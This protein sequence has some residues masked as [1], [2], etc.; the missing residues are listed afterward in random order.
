MALFR[1]HSKN[2]EPQ[3]E[4]DGWNGRP[5]PPM[6]STPTTCIEPVEPELLSRC[7]NADS[8]ASKVISQNQRAI[9]EVVHAP[10]QP[11]MLAQLSDRSNGVLVITAF[12]V[13]IFSNGHLLATYGQNEIGE[14]DPH[15]LG[16]QVYVRF[17]SNG[18]DLPIVGGQ[19]AARDVA[20]L[21]DRTVLSSTR[22]DLTALHASM[23]PPSRIYPEIIFNSLRRQ[24]L[25]T[26]ADAIVSYAASLLTDKLFLHLGVPLLEQAGDRA[27]KDDFAGRFGRARAQMNQKELLELPDRIVEWLWA[28]N[29]QFH[30]PIVQ[31]IA[32]GQG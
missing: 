10:E 8:R 30:L 28:R 19:L 31:F 4:L 3:P 18:V 14:T 2:P 12:R 27:G 29:P 26:S 20:N 25:D 15:Y 1:R 16:T 17:I 11:L 7:V 21:I 22:I 24:G 5:F 13:L 9:H 23:R 32:A 6:Q